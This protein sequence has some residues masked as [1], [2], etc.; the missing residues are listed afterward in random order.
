MR[1]LVEW[2]MSVAKGN[3][4][5]IQAMINILFWYIRRMGSSEN[6]RIVIGIIRSCKT[7]IICLEKN[8]IAEISHEMRRRLEC[9]SCYE[10]VIKKGTGHW[11]ES[12]WAA[13]KTRS[14]QQKSRKAGSLYLGV[15]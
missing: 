3:K 7:D 6:I 13:A 2:L 1:V 12:R 8:K 11:E 14:K 5:N 10:W 9:N 4:N 15:A